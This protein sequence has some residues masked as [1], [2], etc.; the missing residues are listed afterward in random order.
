MQ[1]TYETIR[2]HKWKIILSF[3]LAFFIIFAITVAVGLGDTISILMTANWY[4]ILLNI[5]LEAGIFLV[6]TYRW[7]LILTTVNEYIP[8]RSLLV[9]LMASTFGNNVTPGAAGGE[10]LRAYLLGATKKTPYEIGFASATA[11]RVFEFFPFVLISLFAA[12]FILGW[13]IPIWTKIIVFVMI[14]VS[15]FFFAIVLYAVYRKEI[16]QRVIISIMKSIH[17]LL[18]K[19]IKSDL[20]LVEMN[21]KIIFYIN[22]FSKGFLQVVKDKRIFIIGFILSFFMWALDIVRFYICFITIGVY[23]PIIPLIIIYTIGIL[24]MLV[25]LLPGSWGIREAIIVGLFAVVG[26]AG[27]IVFS[28]SLIDRFVSYIL[29]TIIGAFAAL[30]YGRRIQRSK[31]LKNIPPQ[32]L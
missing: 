1:D 28:A 6:W 29:P 13:E 20:S 26:V 8:F 23:P 11:D 3:A 22:R 7:K 31:E 9:M 14:L 19:I 2:K 10:P 17:P 25:P 5:I 18:V 15:I 32:N 12:F 4:F 27:D 24:I 16:S 30:Y 21:E